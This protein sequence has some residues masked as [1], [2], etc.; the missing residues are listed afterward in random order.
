MSGIAKE[1]IA[2]P[3]FSRAAITSFLS[4]LSKRDPAAWRKAIRRRKCERYQ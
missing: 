1:F 3:E 4:L 2:K